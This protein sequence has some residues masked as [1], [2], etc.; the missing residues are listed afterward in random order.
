MT[1]K[2]SRTVAVF[3]AGLLLVGATLP[4]QAAGTFS[5]L[6]GHWAE[7]KVNDLVTAGII[8]P[9]EKYRPRDPVTRADF[10]K[11]LVLAS[12]LPQAVSYP[13]TFSDVRQE[14]WFYKYV[15]TAA[16]HGVAK[17]DATGKFRPHEGL[18]REQ[19]A[20]MVIRAL[21]D[22]TDAS[23]SFLARFKDGNQ[24]SKWAEV[25]LARA[26]AKGLISGTDQG[27]LFPTQAATRDQAAAVIWQLWQQLRTGGQPI[28][29]PPAGTLSAV[30]AALDL[31]RVVIT[32]SG[33][34]DSG[35]AAQVARYRL[36][37]ATGLQV[38]VPIEA[39]QVAADGQSVTLATGSLIRGT[40]YLLS[41]LDLTAAGKTHTL[42]LYFTAGA[43][44]LALPPVG[45][46]NVTVLGPTRLKVT[47][48]QELDP[49][50][51]SAGPEGSFT[52][53]YAGT[54]FSPGIVTGAVVTAPREVVLTV[55]ELKVGER[56][57]LSAHDLR[58][59]SGGKLS[60]DPVSFSFTVSVGQQAPRLS[61][62]ACTGP[63]SLELTFD[64]ELDVKTAVSAAN[65]RLR[66]TGER[67][68]Q[69]WVTGRTAVLIFPRPFTVGSVYTLE[70]EPLADLWGNRSA[71]TSRTVTVAKDTTPPK[72]V[73]ANALSGTTIEVL[74]NEKLV[75]VG[76][77]LLRRQGRKVDVRRVEQV[78]PGRVL[79][80]TYL[81]R[82]DAYRLELAGALDAA[83]NKA[84]ASSLYFTF[85]GGT[86]SEQAEF[87]PE[88]KQ[89]QLA[90][91]RYDQL[92]V[93][94]SGSMS[95][96]GAERTRNY[97]LTWADDLSEEIAIE[98][99]ELGDDDREVRLTLAQP[100]EKGRTYR[101]FVSA[102]ED[103]SGEEM[104]PAAGYLVPGVTA[105]QDGFI[106]SVTVLDARRLEVVFAEEV[107]DKFS[108]SNYGLVDQKSQRL[109][110]M[111]GVDRTPDPDRVTLRLGQELEEDRDYLFS[112]GNNL[113]DKS[114]KRFTTF[115]TTV[116]LASGSAVRFR[117]Q[118]AQALDSRSFRLTFSRPVQ[119]VR[120]DLPG[121][122]FQ[123]E[124]Y[125]SVVLVRANKSFRSGE[126]Y[127]PE[128]W[129]RDNGGQV[130]DWRSVRLEFDPD[131]WSAEVVDVAAA[132]SQR[133]KA[134]FSSPLDAY[135]ASDESNFYLETSTGALLRPVKAEY[136][137]ARLLVWLT[138][139]TSASLSEERY[140]LVLDGVRDINGNKLSAKE[141]HRFYGVD[142]VPPVV[143]LPYLINQEGL[144]VQLIQSGDQTT[145]AGHPGAVEAESY[146]RVH[147]DDRL[148]AVG[149]AEQDGSFKPLSLGQLQGRRTLRLVV[150]DRAGNSGERSQ[151]YEF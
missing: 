14:H 114:G 93:H 143:I 130:L 46:K 13:P 40:R 120:V 21:K 53:A 147:I 102:I 77:I 108:A 118:E 117:F 25:D 51:V 94:F 140:F 44:D 106:R 148:V 105:E 129:A 36:V 71:A 146:L 69:V 135:S 55:P 11:M 145:I 79:V 131:T 3:L 107:Q 50:S 57:T 60:L 144:P 2:W 20:S 27:F 109:V 1:A 75:V 100:L 89:V 23:V 59:A 126:T 8:S 26:V 127:R 84:P 139:P 133:V 66:E 19:M 141:R 62:L 99:A 47:F 32:F 12:G 49:E 35:S 52:L 16:Y 39:V 76:D 103:A 43:T 33:A 110:P 151:V 82:D 123:Y 31:D 9:G 72:V 142:T 149:R 121:Y 42:S 78:A 67:P 30:A 74:F 98:T 150:T 90:P 68:Q 88:V 128:V 134:E 70:V 137:P 112:A 86:R 87:P 92:L 91:G 132:T 101:Y 80:S 48:E 4:A 97:R 15:E 24:V 95:V 119:E 37:P 115:S 104:I 111:L 122:V 65:Y 6:Q 61:S 17:G 58:A 113:A 38:E 41:V 125:D 73:G 28:T 7:A 116:R 29:T 81:D 124:Y 138:L 22:E 85:V 136:D 56:Y 96:T 64:Q 34:V 10:I 83:G 54:A 18:T 5:D 63:E 45:D